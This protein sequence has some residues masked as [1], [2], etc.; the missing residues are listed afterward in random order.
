MLRSVSSIREHE[1]EKRKQRLL[2]EQ[3]L[4][5]KMRKT[6]RELEQEKRAEGLQTSLDLTNKVKCI[7]RDVR[8]TSCGLF[9]L[10]ERK[11]NKRRKVKI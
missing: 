1:V 10:T 8:K 7:F 11:V 2:E 9:P 4:Q 3:R 5:K 6:P